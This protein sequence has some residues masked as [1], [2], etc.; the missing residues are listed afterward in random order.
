MLPPIA[1]TRTRTHPQGID[2]AILVYADVL[3]PSAPQLPNKHVSPLVN[4]HT[5]SGHRHRHL[6]VRVGH[7]PYS[8]SA[9]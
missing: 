3:Y 7:P 1:N 9:C 8:T 5:P 6:D 2:I 4:T